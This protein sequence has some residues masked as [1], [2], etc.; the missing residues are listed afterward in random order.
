M[1]GDEDMILQKSIR[2]SRIIERIDF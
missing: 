1:Y 2:S